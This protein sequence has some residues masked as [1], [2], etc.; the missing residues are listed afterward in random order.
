MERS[1]PNFKN[2]LRFG[3]SADGWDL[4]VEIN[5]DEL[6]IIQGE[7]GDIEVIDITI[8]DLLGAKVERV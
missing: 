2:L 4:L 3:V 6:V 8:F 1:Q 7:M 5:D